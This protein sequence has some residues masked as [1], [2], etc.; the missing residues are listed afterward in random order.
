M[1][2]Y[3]ELSESLFY[4][5]KE[6]LLAKGIEETSEVKTLIDENDPN[7]KVS[8]LSHGT[9]KHRVVITLTYTDKLQECGIHPISYYPHNMYIKVQ[10]KENRCN[11][12]DQVV[13]FYPVYRMYFA[14]ERFVLLAAECSKEIH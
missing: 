5:A 3:E 14:I 4:E 11:P 2:T 7:K 1:K 13:T 12:K 10:I 8:Y 9:R 6:R